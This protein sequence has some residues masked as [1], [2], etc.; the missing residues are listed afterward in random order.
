MPSDPCTLRRE[1]GNNLRF[2]Q[3]YYY[4]LNKIK[5]PLEKYIPERESFGSIISPKGAFFHES[6]SPFPEMNAKEKPSLAGVV[7]MWNDVIVL[8]ACSAQ[9]VK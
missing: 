9:K 5:I 1:K 3:F 7:E 4:R 6:Q 8:M 2:S